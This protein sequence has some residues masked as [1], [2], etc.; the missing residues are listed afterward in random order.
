[1]KKQ[2]QL[3]RRLADGGEGQQRLL[4]ECGCVCACGGRGGG[5]LCVALARAR[6]C[7]DAPLRVMHGL[8]HIRHTHL[9]H[10]HT[11]TQMT[12][13]SCVRA[14]TCRSCSSWWRRRQ[15]AAWMQ[16][17]RR[18]CWQL[19]SRSCWRERAQRR[20]TRQRKSRRR[21]QRSRCG[22]RLC[23]CCA[24]S[25]RSTMQLAPRMSHCRHTLVIVMVTPHCV[26][27]TNVTP[28]GHGQAR[29]R[30]THAGDA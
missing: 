9:V 27:H 24:P 26:P 19:L 15:Q 23:V 22:V 7:A 5:C 28:A 12:P 16:Q 11:V 4:S 1:M 30:Q 17:Q 8:H 20:G 10:C 25:E 18:A 13:R 29:P 14:W 6:L 21:K 3:L 2:R